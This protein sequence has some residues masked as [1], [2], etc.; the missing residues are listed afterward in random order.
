MCQGSFESV[1]VPF[2]TCF[3]SLAKQPLYQVPQLCVSLGQLSSMG[4]ART[5][6]RQWWF[7]R[8][9]IGYF[10]LKTETSGHTVHPSHG[11]AVLEVFRV[12]FCAGARN[13]PGDT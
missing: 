5:H 8:K 10:L 2:W 4:D 13:T 9:G 7:P 12:C 1:T 6:L 3:L 11:N